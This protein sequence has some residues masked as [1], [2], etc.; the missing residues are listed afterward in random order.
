MAMWDLRLGRR[1]GVKRVHSAHEVEGWLGHGGWWEGGRGMGE[2][3]GTAAARARAAREARAV[4][5]RDVI[6]TPNPVRDSE[7]Q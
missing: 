6:E 1:C 7:V 2:G 5:A 3:G 4:R